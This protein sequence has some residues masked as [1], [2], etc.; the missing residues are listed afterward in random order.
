MGFFIITWEFWF[1]P[2]DFS[3]AFFMGEKI[4]WDFQKHKTRYKYFL[5]IQSKHFKKKNP[6]T[7]P[8]RGSKSIFSLKKNGKRYISKTYIYPQDKWY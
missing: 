5:E 8:S 1:L 7:I 3:P 4:P 6:I 2:W